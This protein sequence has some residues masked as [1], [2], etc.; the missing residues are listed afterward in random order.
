MDSNVLHLFCLV[1]MGHLYLF[2]FSVILNLSLIFKLSS[3]LQFI[4]TLSKMIFSLSVPLDTKQVIDM[5]WGEKQL[6]S[7]QQNLPW[8]KIGFQKY[9]PSIK[10]HLGSE[11]KAMFTGEQLNRKCF[12]SGNIIIALVLCACSVRDLRCTIPRFDISRGYKCLPLIPGIG[13]FFFLQI[14]CY[15]VLEWWL[16]AYRLSLW[17]LR[18]SLILVTSNPNISSLSEKLNTWLAL[19]SDTMDIYYPYTSHTRPHTHKK[20]F[21]WEW[22]F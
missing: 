18:V 1:V 20:S 5:W 9:F 21:D 17:S 12:L 16:K 15:T 14:C 2:K 8:E 22:D 6:C 4:F 3:G 10:E 7:L 11:Q 13:F 19:N